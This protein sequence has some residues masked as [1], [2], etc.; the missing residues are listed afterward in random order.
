MRE[1]EPGPKAPGSAEGAD[2]PLDL[3]HGF[4]QDRRTWSSQ[5][6]A[7][8]ADRRRTSPTPLDSGPEHQRDLMQRFAMDLTRLL[9][10]RLDQAL[11]RGLPDLELNDA[12]DPPDTPP[13]AAMPSPD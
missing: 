2:A 13:Q 5:V 1:K 7:F 8:K 11:L 3:V 9:Q 10:E 12:E 4:P 6:A